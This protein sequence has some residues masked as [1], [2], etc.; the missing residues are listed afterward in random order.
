MKIVFLS[1]FYNHHQ[2]FISRELYALTG[3]QFRFIATEEMPE[4]RRKL[5]YQDQTESFVFYYGEGEATR[6]AV[7]DWIDTADIVIVG[8]AP[9][10][11]LRRRRK[12]QK[13]ILRYSE[14]LLKKGIQRWKWPVR[15]LRLHRQNPRKARI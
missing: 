8:S 14:H 4:E 5:G 12:K 15:W 1:N 2:A 13:V 7:R 6:K 3:G 11:L 10:K 9:D